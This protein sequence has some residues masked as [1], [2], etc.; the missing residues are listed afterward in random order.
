MF[1]LQ[2]NFCCSFAAHPVTF[3]NEKDRILCSEFKMLYMAITRAKQNL[4]IFDES[5]RRNP[6]EKYWTEQQLVTVAADVQAFAKTGT[7]LKK[8]SPAA[9]VSSRFIE[10]PKVGMQRM[11]IT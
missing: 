1:V 10:L 4:W 3:D 9:W 11:N 7:V 2:I 5:D 6:I 8:S